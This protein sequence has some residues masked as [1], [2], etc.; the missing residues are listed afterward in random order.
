MID[1]KKEIDQWGPIDAKLLYMSFWFEPTAFGAF[2]RWGAKW[3]KIIGIFENY[4]ITYLWEREEMKQGGIGVI[5]NILS[6]PKKKEELWSAYQD[7]Q[8]RLKS[9]ASQIDSL[10]SRDAPL[11][12]VCRIAVNWG[13]LL[14]ETWDVGVTPEIANFAAPF[15][16][17]GKISSYVKAEEIHSVLEALLAPEDLSFHQQSEKELF[18]LHLNSMGN[19][20]GASLGDYSKKWHWVE[21]SY[22]ESRHLSAEHFKNQLTSLSSLENVRAKLASIDARLADVKKRKKEIFIRQKFPKQLQDLSDTLSHSIWWQDHRKGLAWWANEIL[23]SLARWAENK[24]GVPFEDIMMYNAEEWGALFK[25]GK[26][27]QEKTLNDRRK[28]CVFDL[29][30][31]GIKE[32]WGSRAETVRD[33]FVEG[34]DGITSEVK[35]LRGVVVSSGKITGKVRIMLSPRNNL[36]E[37]GEV[38]VAPMT[39]PDYIVAMRKASAIVTDVGGL[40]SH[41]AIVSRELKKPCIVGTKIATKVLKDGDLVEVDAEKGIVKIIK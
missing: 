21:N 20:S 7:V 2:K 15:Y 32:Y 5:E 6:I 13:K 36:V 38:L 39:S 31:E 23:D 30:P 1:P 34:E 27:V 37:E 26:K 11:K 28:L 19:P 18:E 10:I 14:K 4:R 35:E 33:I 16:F 8:N 17:E 12:E 40:M 25:A 22:F 41:A 3:P 9:C 24:L 29:G